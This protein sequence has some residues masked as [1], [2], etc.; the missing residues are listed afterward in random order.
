MKTLK[1][2]LCIIAVVAVFFCGVAYQSYSNH[3]DEYVE[4]KDTVETTKTQEEIDR[5][6]EKFYEEYEKERLAL[7]EAIKEDDPELYA[8]R[9]QEYDEI[10]IGLW[11]PIL[12]PKTEPYRYEFQ[13]NGKCQRYWYST[14]E[15]REWLVINKGQ[16]KITANILTF[17][18]QKPKGGVIDKEWNIQE[19]V[20][21]KMMVT[22]EEYDKFS[23]TY[24]TCEL[25]LKRIK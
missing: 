1:I 5:D 25:K 13:K 16:Y 12:D 22:Y 7:K 15:P 23:K 8:Y 3:T 18:L 24:R 19:I 21:G 6:N 4:S 11:E 17:Q 2:I 20:D 14:Y 9:Y 10:V